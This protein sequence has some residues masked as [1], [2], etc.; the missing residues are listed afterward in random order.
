MFISPYYD[1]DVAANFFYS[2]FFFIIKHYVDSRVNEFV[3][4][5]KIQFTLYRIKY[6][7]A[8]IFFLRR[9]NLIL[10]YPCILFIFW[11]KGT[12]RL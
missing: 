2:V 3:S 8:R 11:V 4:S 10:I 7:M 5:H 1:I 12:D 6:E 9:E